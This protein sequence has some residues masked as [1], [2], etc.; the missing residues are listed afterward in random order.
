MKKELNLTDDQVNA[1]KKNHEAMAQKFKAM[2]EDKNLSEDQK[3][4]EMK[5]FRKQQHESLKSILTPEQLQKLEQQKKHRNHRQ[6][7]PVQ[8]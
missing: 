3:K 2:R 6:Q 1:L 8:S 7:P 4:A 5:E